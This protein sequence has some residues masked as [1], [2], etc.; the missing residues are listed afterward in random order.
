MSQEILSEILQLDHL[1]QL[2]QNH[3]KNINK[4]VKLENHCPTRFY[5]FAQHLRV[6]LFSTRRSR[7]QREHFVSFSSFTSSLLTAA[8][9][10]FTRNRWL[11][12]SKKKKQSMGSFVLCIMKN[13]QTRRIIILFNSFRNN[14]KG[15][16]YEILFGFLLPDMKFWCWYYKTLVQKLNSIFFVG[17]YNG[18][19]YFCW[20]GPSLSLLLWNKTFQ[21]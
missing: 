4:C 1:F 2:S 15:L 11:L 6:V 3:C 8:L 9:R 21:R 16:V 10:A 12:W 20:I 19:N 18:E 7:G 13:H 17:K 14:A 5:K